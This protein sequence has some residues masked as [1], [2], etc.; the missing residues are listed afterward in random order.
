MKHMP[1][2]DLTTLLAQVTPLSERKTAIETQIQDL[3][4]DYDT[5]LR[6]LV[7]EERQVDDEIK[8]LLTQVNALL[9]VTGSS[10][11]ASSSSSRGRRRGRNAMQN[12]MTL[13]SAIT[14]VLENR[15]YWGAEQAEVPGL[16]TREIADAIQ[17]AQIW[18][19]SNPSLF[20]SQVSQTVSRMKKEGLV[21]QEND[22]RYAL[23]VG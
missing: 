9:G 23:I 16:K 3:K 17:K 5:Q 2:I 20:L 6:G 14:K 13:Q 18:S 19:P 8:K 1:Q 11:A 7:N 4:A 10:A 15:A 21:Q 12:S 22:R